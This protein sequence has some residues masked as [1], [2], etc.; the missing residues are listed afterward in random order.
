[1]ILAESFCATPADASGQCRRLRRLYG[2]PALVEEYLPGAEV[3]VAVH[4]NGE[5][6]S[7]LGMMEI[8]PAGEA[9]APF[10]Y[11]LEVKRAWRERVC[12]HNPPRR[13][14]ALVDEIR[15]HALTAFRLL[16]CRDLARF[17]FRLD[18][19]GRPR[20]LECNPLPGLDSANSDVVILSRGRLSYQEL[21]QG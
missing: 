4:G 16:G 9:A 18:G 6:C 10:L 2:S 11:S 15:A 17:D 13:S 21:V 7:V 3:T 1:G 20:F 5:G 8:A 19:A 14:V 12:Y